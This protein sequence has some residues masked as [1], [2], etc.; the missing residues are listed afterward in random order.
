MSK[1]NW[2]FTKSKT[3]DFLYLSQEDVIAAGGLDMQGTLE[4]VE[5][6]FRH[7]GLGEYVQP[8]KPVLR[9]GDA[10]SEETTGR[11]MAMPAYLGGDINVAGIKWI[12]S[13]PANPAKYGMPRASAVIVLNDTETGYP[14]AIM[15]GTVVSA[16]R[17][18]AATGVGAKYLARP[19]SEVIGLIGAGVQSRTQ[20]MALHAVLP[21]VK[22][23]RVYDINRAKAEAFA[24]EMSEKLKLRVVAVDSHKAALAEADAFVTATIGTTAYVTPEM[25]KPGAF[26]SEISFWD[27]QLETLKI[28]DKIVV[29]DWKQVSHHK[30]DVAYRAVK[31]G[32]IPESK[33]YGELGE[34]VAGKKPGRERPD[35]RILFN[36]IGM[37]INDVAEAYRVFR[38]AVKLGIGQRL[39]L[40]KNPVWA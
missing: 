21:N 34:V 36:P 12:P 22:E 26:H 35:E 20:L 33:I 8:M 23:A 14:I 29:D 32:V 17:T 16:M 13:K 39:P 5:T 38:N 28:Y 11:I 24:Q 1:G 3:V 30:V 27:T 40:W 10:A 2:D 37:G 7:H 15:D 6:G 4:A 9:W 19:D 18:G 25:V 31:A